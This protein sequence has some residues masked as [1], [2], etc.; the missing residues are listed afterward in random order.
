VAVHFPAVSADAGV[1]VPEHVV[2][3]VFPAE[4]VVLN[5]K[6]GTYHGLNPTAGRMLEVLRDTGDQARTAEVIA[7]EFGVPAEQVRTDL[8]D[9]CADLI[10]R[11]L[12]EAGPT[13]G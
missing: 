4:T 12:L 3:R 1:S 7:E 6:T 13:E 2:F 9:L 5:L 10:E 8:A 11:G